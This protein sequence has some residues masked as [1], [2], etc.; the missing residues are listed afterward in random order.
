MIAEMS[1]IFLMDAGT[2]FGGS[3]TKNASAVHALTWQMPISA[4]V[5]NS[6][7]NKQHSNFPALKNCNVKPQPLLL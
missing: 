6:G 1:I 5:V 2:G 4:F 7:N 3:V